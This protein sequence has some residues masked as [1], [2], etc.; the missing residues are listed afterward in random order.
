MTGCLSP[1]PACV[2][3]YENRTYAYEDTIYNTTDGLGACLTATCGDNGTIIRRT[4]ECPGILTTTP[5]TFT[6]TTAPLSTS[7]PAR[8]S[9]SPWPWAIM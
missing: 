6:T 3:T 5:F 9:G 8:L 2:C 4:E 7:K 1:P